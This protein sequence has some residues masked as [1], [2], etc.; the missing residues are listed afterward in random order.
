M[1]DTILI[2][3]P[4]ELPEASLRSMIPE[5]HT[6]HSSVETALAQNEDLMARLKV[7]LRRLTNTENENLELKKNIT[8]LTRRM[9]SVDDDRAVWKSR[10]QSLIEQIKAFE[11]RIVAQK[12]MSKEILD[13]KEKVSRYK[14]Y[15]E[16]IRTQVKP[17]VQNLKN[18]A[19]SLVREVQELHS[20]LS[21]RENEVSELEEKAFNFET[22]LR[23]I[24]EKHLLEVQRLTEH[25]EKSQQNLMSQNHHLQ[26]EVGRLSAKAEKFDEM[27]LREDELENTLISLR[28]ERET[29]LQEMRTRE[30]ELLNELGQA[31]MK[32]I[33]LQTQNESWIEKNEVE[34][35]ERARLESQIV[36]LQEQMS[37]LRFMW[38]EQTE[39]MEKLRASQSSLEKLN[40]EL[41]R[42]LNQLIR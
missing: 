13:L 23:Q 37:S 35:S 6:L 36:G 24:H 38:S 15:Q 10:E 42:Q 31:R 41:S 34:K 28:R 7:T 14:K 5:E 18:Y 22:E 25:S 1:E 39:E 4:D 32:I 21:R 16:K 3:T 2:P 27:R 29:S 11:I 8:Q 17:Y 9:N 12:S 30:K 40:A 33:D 19:D 20:E 26:A